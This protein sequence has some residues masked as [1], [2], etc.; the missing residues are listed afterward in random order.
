VFVKQRRL[1]AAFSGNHDLVGGAQCL[2]AK[3]RVHRALVGNA[4][5]DVVVDEGIEYRVRDLVA[6][7]VRMALRHGL[8]REQII[9]AL[10]SETLPHNRRWK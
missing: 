2:A 1:A 9:G 3:P 10:H 4:E 7:L 5:L 8:A 6:N